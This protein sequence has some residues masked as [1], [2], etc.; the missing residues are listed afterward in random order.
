MTQ[1]SG[2]WLLIIDTFERKWQFRPVYMNRATRLSS[3]LATV[4]VTTGRATWHTCVYLRQTSNS[5]AETSE[6]FQR[7]QQNT[8]L[9]N[10][11]SLA[12]WL[13]IN[14]PLDYVSAGPAK[15]LN[16]QVYDGW[17]SRPRQWHLASSSGILAGDGGLGLPVKCCEC[18]QWREK[19][20]EALGPVIDL[21]FAK[22]ELQTFFHLGFNSKTC[23]WH[24]WWPYMRYFWRMSE[25]WRSIGYIETAKS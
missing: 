14:R 12:P 22:H 24:N 20:F 8:V 16:D 11:A 5:A 19:G 25:W 10:S 18:Y 3:R 7:S 4:L 2:R 13:Q 9:E 15:C 1:G 17:K 6:R 23:Q 21:V